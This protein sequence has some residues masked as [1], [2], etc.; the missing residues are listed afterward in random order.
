MIDDVLA[1]LDAHVAKHIVK[2]CILDFLKNRTRILVTENRTLFY[3]SN[4]ILHVEA[5][6]VTTSDYALESIESDH[7]ESESSSSDELNT[8]V[9]FELDSDESFDREKSIFQVNYSSIRHT[10]DSV[11]LIKTFFTVGNQRNRWPI[12]TCSC[13]LLESMG[14]MV[15]CS[16]FSVIIFNASITKFVRRLASSL[17]Q[18]YKSI[19]CGTA[20][21]AKHIS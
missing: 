16:H 14:T 1:S 19:K 2:H 18:K 12:I 21:T 20:D 11:L 10:F 15:W 9:S 5:G 4:Q 13:S 8:P 3:Y 6:K 17:D 7:F